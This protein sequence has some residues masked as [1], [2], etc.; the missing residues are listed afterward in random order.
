[1]PGGQAVAL[2]VPVKSKN[3]AQNRRLKPKTAL[4]KNYHCRSLQDQLVTLSVGRYFVRRY[5]P[6]FLE[7]FL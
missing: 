5:G 7:V 4:I 3:C 6:V 2:V 1:M